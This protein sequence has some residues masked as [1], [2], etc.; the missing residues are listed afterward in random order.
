MINSVIWRHYLKR[1]MHD[2]SET[3]SYPVCG[4]ARCDTASPVSAADE[5]V[6]FSHHHRQALIYHVIQFNVQL[7]RALD[8]G[9]WCKQTLTSFVPSTPRG[10]LATVCIASS[11]PAT[12]FIVAD[13]PLGCYRQR[14]SFLASITLD[15]QAFSSTQYTV[16]D[17][18]CTVNDSVVL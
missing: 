4:A 15:D 12:R 16:I 6:T 8:C 9:G 14:F 2:K 10:L 7:R 1:K 13:Q 11:P 17:Y 5:V 3:Q 18:C